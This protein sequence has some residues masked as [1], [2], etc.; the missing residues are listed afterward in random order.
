MAACPSVATGVTCGRSRWRVT[1]PRWFVHLD[2]GQS[3]GA[4]PIKPWVVW[5]MEYAELLQQVQAAAALDRATAEGVTRATMVMLAERM[6]H[7]ELG[8]LGARLPLLAHIGYAIDRPD[9]A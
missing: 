3:R 8:P 7:D 2:A 4:E 5:R 6:H 1:Q 9:K